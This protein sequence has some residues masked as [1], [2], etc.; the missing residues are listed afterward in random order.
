MYKYPIYRQDDAYS[1][2]AYCIKM[3]L[4]Y[5]HRD[6]MIKEIKERCRLT[7]QGISVYG[8]V[9]CLKSYHFDVKAYQC[10][11]DTLLKEARLPCIIHV[12][13]DNMT[14]YMVLYKINKRYLLIGDPAKGLIKLKKEKLETIFTGVCICIEHVGR[15]VVEK[16]Q[17]D[18]T[19]LEFVCKHLKNNYRDVINLVTKA[20]IISF[21][22]IFGSFYFQ[23]LINSVEKVDF[24][25]VLIFSAIFIFV[26]LV[27]IIINFQRKSLEITIQKKLNYEYVNKSV[28][29]MLYLSFKA[30]YLHQDGVLLTRVQNLYN[31]SNFFIHFY[32]IVFM[33]LI[34]IIA[35]VLVLFLFSFKIGIIVLTVLFVIAFVVTKAMRQINKWNKKIILSQEKM[36]SG[37]LEYI[38]NFYNNHQFHQINFAREKI[39][40]LFAD[41]NYNIYHRDNKFNYLSAI[42][43]VFVQGLAFLVVIIASY[44]YKLGNISI[45]DIVLFYMLTTYLFEPLFNLISFVVEKDEIMLIYERYKEIIPVKEKRKMK[46]KDKITEIKFDHITYSYGYCKPIIEHLDL[47]INHSIWLKGDTGAGKSTLLGLLMKHDDL[48]KGEILINGVS[49][50]QFDLNSLYRKIIYL[51]KEPFFYQESLRFNL[52]LNRQNEQLLYELLKEFEMEQFIDQLEKV[53]DVDGKPLSS[54][55]R[56]I[57]MIIR[58]LLLNPDVLILDE[59]LSNVD[60]DKMSKILNYLNLY[61][62]EIIVIIVAHQTKIVNQFYDCVIIKDGKIDK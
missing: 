59:A 12:I 19:F 56:Q 46:I 61:R 44:F 4:K 40:Y 45:G 25:V 3:L 31:L 13:N 11:L 2:G 50:N 43:E 30:F 23:G 38:N 5:Y 27:R 48:I 33:D 57:M 21:C 47:V 24:Y 7:S 1:C 16:E 20:I 6:V 17:K 55:Q 54:G 53:I 14:H 34:L 37:Y 60:D 52:L 9:Q 35:I 18:I 29:N 58:A 41:Y 39:N 32:M 8:I 28:I 26:A 36:N 22:S 62:S 10:N 42:S 51:D 49:I 15:Y